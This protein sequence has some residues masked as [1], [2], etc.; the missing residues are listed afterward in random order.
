MSLFSGLWTLE[1]F[2][3][4]NQARARAARRSADPPS[5]GAGQCGA[6]EPPQLAGLMSQLSPVGWSVQGRKTAATPQGTDGRV[7]ERLEKWDVERKKKSNNRLQI[8]RSR[9][10]DPRL[11]GGQRSPR[12]THMCSHAVEGWT[13]KFLHLAPDWALERSYLHP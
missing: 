7:Q 9:T 10:R 12:T 5:A 2:R 13:P 8:P 6:G 1:E 3:K 4:P 11:C